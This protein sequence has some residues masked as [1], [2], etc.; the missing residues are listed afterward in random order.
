MSQVKNP[1]DVEDSV[2]LNLKEVKRAH[3]TE[4]YRIVRGALAGESGDMGSRLGHAKRPWTSSPLDISF[5]ICKVKGLLASSI[6]CFFESQRWRAC[7]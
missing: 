4:I 2:S 3:V 6:Q 1:G 5:L 7:F